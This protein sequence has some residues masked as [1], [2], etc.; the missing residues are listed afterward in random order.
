MKSRSKKFLSCILS[1]LLAFTLFIPFGNKVNAS[2]IQSDYKCF[3][4][5]PLGSITN[6][7]QFKNELITLKN[8]GVYGITTD[9]WWGDVEGS[10]DNQFNWSYYK[11]Y[12]DVVRASGLKW[13][14][15]I[16]THECGGTVG[17]NGTYRP[18]PSW[19]WS[20]DSAD[21]MQFKDELGNWD[22][23]CLSP[24]YSDIYNQ[25][26]DLYASF[27]SNFSSYKDIISSIYLSAGPAGE[28]RFPSYDVDWSYPERGHLECYSK[29][30]I[31]DFQNAMQTKYITISQL[32]NVWGTSLS[33]F[34][35][36]SPPTDGDNF[37]M[38]GYKTQY[39]RDFLTWYQGVLTKH[40]ANIAAK[41][42]SCFDSVFGVRLGVKLAGVHWLMTSPTMPHAAEYCAGL[43]NYS[44]LLEQFK[45][46][47][48]D[49]TFTC[50]EK[51]NTQTVPNEYTAA[52]TL[53]TNVATLANQKGIRHFGE[54]ALA[55][56]NDNQK[57]Q[58]IAE[59]LYN[60]NFSGFTLLRITNLFDT[61]GNVIT[62]E[63]DPFT[64]ALA[65]KP[66]PV[67]V[68]VNNANTFYGQNVYLTGSRWELGNWTT[69]DYP[70]ALGYN[71]GAWTGTIYLGEGHNYE[72]KAIKKDSSGNLI[73]QSGNNESYTV[74]TGGGSF[75]WN[76]TN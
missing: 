69:G 15:I 73:W 75:T 14:P 18:I 13:E 35:Q 48:V 66:V 50:L 24:W 23:E 6:W 51:D 62:S 1:L 21:N 40:L 3:V 2:S 10:G 55:I 63:L 61:N 58:N 22:K 57:Y 44:T 26:G 25:Y 42:H 59:M 41:A 37:F 39:G 71:D 49:L 53:V 8:K 56:T 9:V 20:K 4:M 47:D 72:F 74:P 5:A 34:T 11:T 67:N 31:T 64:D 27:A 16:S 33:S 68:T 19:L 46:S 36:I 54:N 70:F 76:W 38:N 29:A 17:D 28:L 7:D 30:A 32:N 65:L 60:Y 43:Y 52:R 45:A 12:A